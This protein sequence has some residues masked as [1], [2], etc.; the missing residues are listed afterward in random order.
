MKKGLLFVIGVS[1]SLALT[2]QQQNVSGVMKPDLTLTSKSQIDTEQQTNFYAEASNQRNGGAPTTQMTGDQFS[3]SRNAL[4]LLVSQ[5][6]CMTANQSLGIAAFTHRISADWSPA[7][8]NSGYIQASWWNGTAWDSMYWDNDGSQLFRYPSGA[9]LNGAGN[10]NIAAAGMAIAGPYTDGSAWSGYYLADGLFQTNFGHSGIGTVGGNVNGFPRIDITSS[11]DSSVW[12]TG[13]L[14]TDVSNGVGY[15]GASLNH[16]T[17]NGTSVSWALDSIVPAFHLDG[18]GLTDCYTMTHLAFSANGQIGY[19]VFFGVQAVAST[20]ETRGFQPIV[21]ST[22]DGG[23]SWS[24]AWLPYDYSAIFANA[25]IA[26]AAVG[27]AIKPWFSMSNGSEALVDNNGQLHLVCAVEWGSSDDDDSLGYTWTRTDNVHYIW[28]IHTTGMNTWA[29]NLIDSLKTSATTTQ[30]PFSDGSA[31]YDLDARIQASISPS[32]DHIFYLWADTDPAV[33]GGENA[34]PNLYGVGYD[35]TAMTK[36]V[37]K[38][39]TFSD[40]AYWHYN[41]NLALVTG[42]MYTIPSSNSRDRDLSFN[43]LTTFDHYYLDNVTFDESEFTL[44]IGI[45]EAVAAFGTVAAYPNPA[46]DVLNLN[47]TLNNNEKVTVA[48]TNV[49]GETVSSQQYNLNAGVNNLS[50]STYN[51]EAGVYLITVSTGTSTATTRVVVQ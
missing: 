47:V 22:T 35:W 39:F 21:Y 9:I 6:N 40:D 28:D 34:Y 1:A 16:G 25:P 19:A 15:H 20:P 41:S 30:S 38:Q 10:T 51:L 45:S 27:G 46:T 44:T 8:V 26:F 4:T 24:S 33:A 50:M 17:W 49:L 11:N 36:T 2:A 18:A 3:S 37:T 42:S 23:A 5:S 13:G 7:G 31:A 29:G 14:Y 12:V 43:T 48:M 32:R